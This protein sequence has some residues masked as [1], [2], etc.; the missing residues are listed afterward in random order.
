VPR[1]FHYKDTFTGQG[2]RGR[3]AAVL[4][5]GHL[6]LYNSMPF[7]RHFND[8]ATNVIARSNQWIASCVG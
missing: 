5:I 3:A 6:S 1:I 8:G 7:P 4:A 2:R